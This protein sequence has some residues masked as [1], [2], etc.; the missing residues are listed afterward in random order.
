MGK[1]CSE[2]TRR[3]M[4]ILCEAFTL[5]GDALNHETIHR[6]LAPWAGVYPTCAECMMALERHVRERVRE[7]YEGL[8]DAEADVESDVAEILQGVVHPYRNNDRYCRYNYSANDR[9]VV[10][11][12]CPTEVKA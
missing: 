10:W 3:T 5:T 7:N 2:K 1:K 12:V 8:D 4:W 9:E 11:Q 6:S